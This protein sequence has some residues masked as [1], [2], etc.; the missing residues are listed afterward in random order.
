M[1]KIIKNFYLNLKFLLEKTFSN[2]IK[3]K[4]KC[5]ACGEC[6]KTIV[7]YIGK[8]PIKTLEQFELLKQWDKKYNNF[9]PNNKSPDGAIYFKCKS[10]DENNKCKQYHFRS[11]G[12]R[13]YPKYNFS[14]L[15]RGKGLK[16]NCG[17]Y[18]KTPKKFK[19]FLKY[20]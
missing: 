2:K 14:F 7:F 5:K 6:C 19:D 10:L 20:N 18:I 4:G 12:C 16:A 11:I 1:D 17:Y 13:L 8:S 3:I 15:T 9:I